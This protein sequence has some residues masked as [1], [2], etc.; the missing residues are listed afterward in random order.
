MGSTNRNLIR[1][2]KRQRKGDYQSVEDKIWKATKIFFFILAYIGLLL[3]GSS[4]K[5]QADHKMKILETIG[6]GR[7]I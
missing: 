5:S 6:W 4:Y 1:I 2:D 3:A 7:G